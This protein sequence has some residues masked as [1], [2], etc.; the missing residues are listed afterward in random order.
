MARGDVLVHSRT[1]SWATDT[2][3]KRWYDLG[4]VGM[5]SA[6]SAVIYV[7]GKGNLGKTVYWHGAEEEGFL[8]QYVFGRLHAGCDS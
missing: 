1:N 8:K 2:P 7:K 5:Q 3:E 6:G 4:N